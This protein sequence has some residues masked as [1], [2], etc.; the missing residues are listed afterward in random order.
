[1]GPN[2][3][4]IGQIPDRD[5][6]GFIHAAGEWERVRE[7]L[8]GEKPDFFQSPVRSEL[9]HFSV[10]HEKVG[11]SLIYIYIYIF[12]FFFLLVL[13]LSR[14]GKPE[15]GKATSLPLLLRGESRRLK[16]NR[17]LLQPLTYMSNKGF[18]A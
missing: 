6:S 9:G 3:G 2:S 7:T 1:M 13:S 8:G 14:D 11:F 10:V 4:D 5:Q 12:S 16:R 18:S 15:D 17:A